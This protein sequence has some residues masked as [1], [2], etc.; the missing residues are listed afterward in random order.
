MAVAFTSAGRVRHGCHSSTKRGARGGSPPVRAHLHSPEGV[1]ELQRQAGNQATTFAVQRFVGEGAF[2]PSPFGEAT[3]PSADAGNGFEPALPQ[4]PTIANPLLGLRKG[5]GLGTK[6]GNA[7]VKTFQ[8][9]L[10]EVMDA[11]PLT[12]DGKWGNDTQRYFDGLNDGVGT[13]RAEFVGNPIGDALFGGLDAVL[14]LLNRLNGGGGGDQAD[15]QVDGPQSELLER[16]FDQITVEF[17]RMLKAQNKGLLQLRG[18]L[19]TP[20]KNESGIVGDLIVRGANFVFDNTLGTAGTSLR[21]SVHAATAALPKKLQEAIVDKPFDEALSGARDIAKETVAPNAKG[22]D[23][24]DF[25]MSQ[26]SGLIGS[27][28]NA[29]SAFLA[30]KPQL[31]KMTVAERDALTST[32]VDARVDRA[33]QVLGGLIQATTRAPEETY[34]KSLRAW[35]QTTARSGLSDKGSFRTDVTDLQF[36]GAVGEVPGVLEIKIDFDPNNPFAP[37]TAKSA[38]ITGLSAVI[39]QKLANRTIGS[40]GFPMRAKGDVSTGIFSAIFDRVNVSVTMDERGVADIHRDTDD[41]GGAYLVAKGQDLTGREGA[42][43]I[44][45][46]IQG[47]VLSSIGGLGR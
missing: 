2:G 38:R 21:T 13:Q 34:D 43:R 23:H 26:Q 18:D 10:N 30:A 25:F 47:V 28:H 5:D 14:E 8:A 6:A 37:V 11:P 33:A 24:N 12:L 32:G 16:S 9:K 7:K 19:G 40:L 27:F 39:R 20:E 31:R 42:R 45:L 36:L 4:A 3:G 35:T 15:G 46:D 17:S 1:L 29:L 22:A 41:D 44:F